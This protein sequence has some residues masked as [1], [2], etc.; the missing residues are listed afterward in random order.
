M[1]TTRLTASL[2]AAL[3]LAACG[4]GAGGTAEPVPPTEPP[5]SEMKTCPDGTQVAADQQCPELPPP[6]PP[7]PP[8]TCPDGSEIPADQQCPAPPPPQTDLQPFPYEP[9]GHYRIDG[10]PTPAAAD[11][12]HMPVY[13]DGKR[14]YVGV[15]QG[16]SYY[17]TFTVGDAIA[18]VEHDL[19]DALLDVGQRGDIEIRRGRIPDGVG[20]NVM[21]AY[22]GQAMRSFTPLD[23][24]IPA[25]RIVGPASA[26]DIAR[27][28]RA[29]QM[30]NAALPEGAKLAISAPL[31]GLTLH[32]NLRPVDSYDLSGAEL[33]N[34]IH[35]EWI[36]GPEYGARTGQAQSGAFGAYFGPDNGGGGYIGF[37]MGASAY[38]RDNEAIAVLAHELIH[39]LADF[40]HVQ[41]Q[42]ATIMEASSQGRYI[43]QDG[44]RQPL[45]LLFPVDREALRAFFGLRGDGIV[46]LDFGEWSAETMR[47]DGNGPHANFGVALRNGYAE[48]W[49]YGPVP[50]DAIADNQTLSGWVTWR[51]ALLGFTPAAETVSGDAS[52]HVDVEALTGNAAFMNLENWAPGAAPRLEG[53]GTMWGDGDL[54]Y[55]IAVTGNTFRETGGGDAGRLTGIFTGAR[56]EGAA[57]T[58]ERSDLTA[59]FGASRE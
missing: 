21:S 53:T 25:V 19:A 40:G 55:A 18:R 37:N 48:P 44:V 11:A 49:A 34:T 2:L 10:L 23:G 15:D 22:L 17:D 42:F 58:L 59:A 33:P 31:P 57:G 4:G 56:H 24:A 27:T 5:P 29:V 1:R 54:R 16:P 38:L 30:V 3:T 52:I 47:I 36:P 32:D 28:I 6:P 26:D 12:R 8:R 20:G 41:P 35:V 45:S 43:M 9:S 14:L 7:E 46:T 51:G 50:A 13:R 39:A